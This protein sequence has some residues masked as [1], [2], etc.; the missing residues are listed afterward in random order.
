MKEGFLAWASRSASIRIP[1]SP[2]LPRAARSGVSLCRP[3][4]LADG[5]PSGH[6]LAVPF[7]VL[8]DKALQPSSSS[9]RN[10]RI[11]LPAFS[12]TEAFSPPQ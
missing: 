12:L 2:A 5:P 7:A 6:W 1:K 8:L 4:K 11:T 10:E 9:D 3:A